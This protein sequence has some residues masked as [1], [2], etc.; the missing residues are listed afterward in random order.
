MYQWIIGLGN[1]PAMSQQYARTRHN[2]GG[3][4]V[5]GLLCKLNLPNKGLVEYRHGQEVTRLGIITGYI[6]SSGIGIAKVVHRSALDSLLVVHDDVELP[7]GEIRFK[8][9]GSSK[10]HNGLRN[11][12]EVMGTS[13]YA[14]LRVG[15]GKRSPLR[16]YVLEKH[17][18]E[19][20]GI[21]QDNINY[22]YESLDALI[23]KNFRNKK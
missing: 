1:Y 3:D 10:G 11:I 7:Y 15:V 19:E 4:L 2:T 23:H 6:N 17:T 14:R 16:D 21:L 8:F 5:L 12:T 22:C 18:P 20:W 9:G 13:E